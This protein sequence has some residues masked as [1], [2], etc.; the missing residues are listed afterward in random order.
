MTIISA[1]NVSKTYKTGQLE[2]QALRGV[3]IRV[4]EGEMIAIMGLLDVGKPPY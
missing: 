2:V 4:E 3:D 1:T